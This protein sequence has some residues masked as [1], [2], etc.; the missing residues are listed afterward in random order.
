LIGQFGVS[1]THGQDRGD[2]ER[3]RAHR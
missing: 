1:P 2:D 3:I